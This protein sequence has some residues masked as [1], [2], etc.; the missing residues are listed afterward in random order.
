MDSL[1]KTMNANFGFAFTMII[2][3]MATAYTIFFILLPLLFWSVHTRITKVTQDLKKLKQAIEE[4]KSKQRTRDRL[5]ERSPENRPFEETL[6]ES[7]IE[8][9]FKK[10]LLEPAYGSRKVFEQKEDDSPEDR[11]L[12]E[13]FREDHIIKPFPI[14]PPN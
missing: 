6:R 12:E 8:P 11:Q 9:L 5:K 2:I 10:R 14:H 13:A 7:E 3:A 4:L 1:I